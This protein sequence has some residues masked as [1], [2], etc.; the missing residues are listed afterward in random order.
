VINCFP[1][2]SALECNYFGPSKEFST[3]MRDG[4]L[5]WLPRPC[6]SRGLAS[7]LALVEGCCFSRSRLNKGTKDGS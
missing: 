4:W 7:R 5:G 6:W 1:I 3:S 2:P